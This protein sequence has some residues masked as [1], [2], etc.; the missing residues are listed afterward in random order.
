MAT[1]QFMKA[2]EMNKKFQ[3][4]DFTLTHCFYAS[5]GGFVIAVPHGRDGN[6][7]E[8]ITIYH[9]EDKDFGKRFTII[10]TAKN[11]MAMNC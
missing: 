6:Q 5:M 8:D 7:V 4:L 9:L 10:V 2:R 1:D 11:V 3:R